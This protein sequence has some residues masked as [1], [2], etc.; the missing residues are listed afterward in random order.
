METTA[1][2]IITAWNDQAD[3]FNKWDDLGEDEKI[4]FAFNYGKSALE[5]FSVEN[6]PKVEGVILIEVDGRQG[7]Y[8]IEGY[9]GGR[10]GEYYDFDGELLEDATHWC[11]LNRPA[12]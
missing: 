8:Q 2:K 11:E 6:S 10:D 9:H 1:D 4:E 12:Q 3:E 7:K 5:W